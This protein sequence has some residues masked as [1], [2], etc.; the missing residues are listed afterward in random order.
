MLNVLSRTI[1]PGLEDKVISRS[2]STPITIFDRVAS[3]E[4]AIVGWSH[5]AGVPA[6]S[7][8]RQ[9]ASSCQNPHSR[10][11]AGGPMGVQSRGNPHGHPH[12][13]PRR[14]ADHERQTIEAGM[15]ACPREHRS[16][17]RSLM[18][19]FRR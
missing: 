11:A 2:A 15:F 19:I 3:S 4:G 7:D 1:Y 14:Q 9:I 13:L 17:G 16:Q 8:L 12:R 6:V 5:E 10:C 18:S